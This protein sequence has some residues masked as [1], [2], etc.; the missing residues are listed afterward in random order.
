MQTMLRRGRT[1]RI[2]LLL[3]VACSAI[4]LPAWAGKFNRVLSVGDPA[5]A[6]KDLIGIDDKRHGL[7]D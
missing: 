2:A 1:L 5:P 4:A 7:A 6:W 3:A